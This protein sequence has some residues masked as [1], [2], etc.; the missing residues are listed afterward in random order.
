MTDEQDYTKAVTVP[1]AASNNGAAMPVVGLEA[2]RKAA[3]AGSTTTARPVPIEPAPAVS[4]AADVPS[5]KVIAKTV[6]QTPQIEDKIMSATKPN[7]D[8]FTAEAAKNHRE[9]HDTGMQVAN[10]A[11][12]GFEELT[13][14]SVTLAQESAA[15][16]TEAV[17][18]LMACKTINELTAEQTRFAQETLETAI[19]T[20]TK[21]SEMSVKMATEMFEPLNAQMTKSMSRASE[22]AKAA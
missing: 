20:V 2:A 11:L 7:F 3:R 10:L 21:L 12:R 14:T 8:K 16:G 9:L 17:K 4:R 19:N 13:K 22:Y 1:G 5:V 15:K 18:A 6:N